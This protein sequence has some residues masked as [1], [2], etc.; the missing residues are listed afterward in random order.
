MDIDVHN[1]DGVEEAFYTPDRVMTVSFHK[2]GGDFFPWNFIDVGHGVGENYSMNVPLD[3]GIDD[4]G[5]R[6]LFELVMQKVMEVYQ[7]NATSPPF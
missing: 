7:P 6:F 1:R 4:T 3:D 5:F 2:D